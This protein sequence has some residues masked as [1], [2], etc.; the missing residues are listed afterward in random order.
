MRSF[1]KLPKTVRIAILL[2]VWQMCMP[3]LAHSQPFAGKAAKASREYAEHIMRELARKGF[4]TSI[5]GLMAYFK[6]KGHEEQNDQEKDDPTAQLVRTLKACKSGTQDR[7]CD[8]L[9]LN[10]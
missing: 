9:L 3:P 1:G 8:L 10:Q 6:Q 2:A 7:I 4:E 5:T